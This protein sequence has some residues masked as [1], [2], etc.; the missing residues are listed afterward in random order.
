MN[1]AETE[2]EFTALIREYRNV[3]WK[4]CYIYSKDSDE[5]KDLYQETVISLWKG[6]PNF[7]NESRPSTWIYR[8]SLN[9]CI[10]FFRRFSRRLQTISLTEGWDII[11]EQDDSSEEIQQ[12]YQSINHLGK[13][14][15]ALVLLWLEEKSYAEIAQITGISETNVATRLNRIREKLRKISSN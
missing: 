14:E 8:V 12:L 10:S 7:R 2:K 13:L 6:F 5:L 4:V 9:S 1:R 15:K 3:I 11:A